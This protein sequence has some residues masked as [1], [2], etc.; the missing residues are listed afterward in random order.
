V[1]STLTDPAGRGRHRLGR[2]G[3]LSVHSFVTVV[4]RGLLLSWRQ[5]GRHRPYLAPRRVTPVPSPVPAL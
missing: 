3:L 4:Y 5:P 2:P 1:T